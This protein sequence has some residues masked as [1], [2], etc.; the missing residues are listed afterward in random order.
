MNRQAICNPPLTADEAIAHIESG[1][2]IFVTGSCTMSRS[3]RYSRSA[4]PITFNPTCRDT[5]ASI[6]YSSVKMCAAL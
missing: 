2:R 4:M 6:P 1:M 3:Y 5:C